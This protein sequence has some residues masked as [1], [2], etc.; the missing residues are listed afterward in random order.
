MKHAKTA[1]LYYLAFAL[2]IYLLSRLLVGTMFEPLINMIAVGAFFAILLYLGTRIRNSEIKGKYFF[3]MRI[4]SVI[5]LVA[6][7]FT[8]ITGVSMQ[9]TWFGLVGGGVAFAAIIIMLF[10]FARTIKKTN[11]KLGEKLLLLGVFCCLMT[12]I[13]LPVLI[14]MGLRAG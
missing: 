6:A 3:Y 8:S 12:A 5:F 11:E 14:I 2:A 1:I 13:V 9:D 7:T 4:L 10:D